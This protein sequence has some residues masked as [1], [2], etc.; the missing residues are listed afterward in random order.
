MGSIKYRNENPEEGTPPA[1][2]PTL[3]MT[4]RDSR[5]LAEQRRRKILELIDGVLG[6]PTEVRTGA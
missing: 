5:L 6:R 3:M 2:D 1:R 4:G